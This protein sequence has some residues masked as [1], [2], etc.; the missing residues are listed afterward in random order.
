MEVIAEVRNLPEIGEG[1]TN[2]ADCEVGDLILPIYDAVPRQGEDDIKMSHVA[3]QAAA[4]AAAVA[5]MEKAE[6]LET[7]NPIQ[8]QPPPG[9]NVSGEP[10]QQQYKLSTYTSLTYDTQTKDVVPEEVRFV[11]RPLSCLYHIYVLCRQLITLWIVITFTCSALPPLIFFFGFIFSS[12][13]CFC[14]S[15][16]RNVEV[17]SFKAVLTLNHFII[18]HEEL[19]PVD[20]DCGCTNETSICCIAHSHDFKTSG[21]KLM[22]L[23]HVEIETCCCIETLNLY[24]GV[25]ETT[26]CGCDD[27]DL[28]LVCMEDTKGLQRQ[29]LKA[30]ND[31][32]EMI[33]PHHP[34][35]D[36][37][38]GKP[39]M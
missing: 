2:L 9:Y 36:L 19:N 13:S 35:Y 24:T 23:K 30:R 39:K 15:R 31:C 8:R 17:E 32:R 26:C 27:P 22:H 21:T 5:E 25:K 10:Q 7:I 3:R 37:I 1:V 12:I 14:G 38:T 20:C 33:V 34:A 28:Q 4:V 11:G 6:R 29:L 16:N 18:R